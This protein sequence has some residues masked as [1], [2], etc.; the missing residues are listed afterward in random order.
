MARQRHARVDEVIAARGVAGGPRGP[1]RRPVLE[2]SRLGHGPAE[3]DVREAI[4][5]EARGERRE[6]LATRRAAARDDRI[7][8][9]VADAFRPKNVACIGIEQRH[10]R[11]HDGG[12]ERSACNTRL[13]AFAVPRYWRNGR[14]VR[15]R[16][17]RFACRSRAQ[18]LDRSARAR[19]RR[20]QGRCTFVNRTKAA[21][22]LASC[23]DAL[24]ATSTL[25]RLQYFFRHGQLARTMPVCTAR[26]TASWRFD[27]RSFE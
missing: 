10:D 25:S 2:K 14:F 9:G 23:D 18:F 26:A 11:L 24:I 12:P 27:A 16:N 17:R 6:G 13:G 4:E 22:R 20:T 3:Q 5:S 21:V 1:R 7:G 8:D 19:R 15:V